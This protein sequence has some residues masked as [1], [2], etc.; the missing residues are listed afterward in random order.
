MAKIIPTFLAFIFLMSRPFFNARERRASLILLVVLGLFAAFLA[1]CIDVWSKMD[2]GPVSPVN[3]RGLFLSRLSDRLAR[4]WAETSAWLVDL[5]GP[6][7]PT[8]ALGAAVLLLPLAL[9]HWL[10]HRN[11]ADPD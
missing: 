4:I 11:A 9:I 5:I 8:F 6:A 2:H 10:L 7:A 3:G 1:L